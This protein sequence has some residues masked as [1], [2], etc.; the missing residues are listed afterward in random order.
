MSLQE[1]PHAPTYPEVLDDNGL[2]LAAFLTLCQLVEPIDIRFMHGDLKQLIKVLGIPDPLI[3][4]NQSHFSVFEA[5]VILCSQLAFPYCLWDLE[6]KF[7]R[8]IEQLLCCINEL[9]ALIWEKWQFL[10]EFDTS[11]L[12]PTKLQEYANAICAA[13]APLDYQGAT[14]PDGIIAH[15]FGPIEGQRADRGV[16]SMSNLQEMCATHA[17]DLSGWQLFLYGDPAYGDTDTI[18]STQKEA[19]DLT[20]EEQELNNLM[21]KY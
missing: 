7:G 3:T 9:S 16:L 11:C 18:I 6:D 21:L 10:L 2:A 20:E 14:C 1:S 12:T 19:C 13:G 8:K 17:R 5:I 4:S 15:C